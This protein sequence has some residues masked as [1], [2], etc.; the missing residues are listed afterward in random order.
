MYVV[1]REAY[2]FRFYTGMG[3]RVLVFHEKRGIPL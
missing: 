1:Q 2:D 3:K